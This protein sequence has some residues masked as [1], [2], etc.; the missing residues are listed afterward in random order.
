MNKKN[1]LWHQRK[2]INLTTFAL[3]TAWETCS[4]PKGQHQDQEHMSSFTH[5]KTE[6]NMACVGAG[7]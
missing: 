3:H 4:D 7:L 1:F 5:F 6:V 2:N